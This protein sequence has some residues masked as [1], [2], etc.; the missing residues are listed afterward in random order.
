MP[1]KMPEDMPKN[2]SK[3]LPKNISKHLPG[4]MPEDTANKMSDRM[5]ENMSDKMAENLSIIKC[6]NIMVGIERNKIIY[7]SFPPSILLP[8]SPSLSSS[9]FGCFLPCSS[10]SGNN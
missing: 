3:Y 4:R 8:L 1:N 10:K 5:P 9:H 7:F 6:I 2:M